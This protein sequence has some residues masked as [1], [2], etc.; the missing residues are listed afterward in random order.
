M[1]VLEATYEL[2]HQVNEAKFLQ[3]LKA[4]L[5]NVKSV[6]QDVVEPEIFNLADAAFG[7]FVVQFQFKSESEELFSQF[8]KKLAESVSS[9]FSQEVSS[10]LKTTFRVLMPWPDFLP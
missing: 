3:S 4:H 8:E 6:F 9:D 10:A 5:L 1:I 2:V 7:A